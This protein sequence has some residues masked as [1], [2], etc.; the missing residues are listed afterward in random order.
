M[1]DAGTATSWTDDLR[2]RLDKLLDEHRAMLQALTGR[3]LQEP[4]AP[5]SPD[6]SFILRDGDMIDSV[7]EAYAAACLTSR[8]LIRELHLEDEVTGRGRRAL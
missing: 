4:G 2:T 6:R 5:S 7:Q 1:T 3:S 8:V